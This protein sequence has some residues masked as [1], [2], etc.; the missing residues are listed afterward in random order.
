MSQTWNFY[1]NK[2]CGYD[3]S[4]IIRDNQIYVV[5]LIEFCIDC[6]CFAQLEL[7]LKPQ[8][9]EI[10]IFVQNGEWK[11]QNGASHL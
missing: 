2:N 8:E 1:C 7:E 10:E 4:F 11:R 9:R 5:E 6:V 3:C